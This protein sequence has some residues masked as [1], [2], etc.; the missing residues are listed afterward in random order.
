MK[1]LQYLKALYQEAIFT[2]NFR[3]EVV[4]IK[5]FNKLLPKIEKAVKRG[6]WVFFY[7]RYLD[8]GVSTH[9]ERILKTKG[10]S[11]EKMTDGETLKIWGWAQ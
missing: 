1:D 10:F 2:K 8:H 6:E 9:L 11:V 5:I 3:N 4:A 7:R